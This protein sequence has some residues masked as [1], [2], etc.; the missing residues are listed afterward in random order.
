MPKPP[1]PDSDTAQPAE[2]TLETGFDEVLPEGVAAGAARRSDPEWVEAT[3]TVTRPIP[4]EALDDPG[5]PPPERPARRPPR[6]LQVAAIAGVAVLVLGAAL[7][8]RSHHRKQVLAKG[9]AHAVRVSWADTHAGYREASQVLEPLVPIDVLEAGAMRAYALA[10]LA[11]DYRD[12]RAG[13]EAE[14]LLLEPERATEVPSAAN[15]ARAA[16]ALGRREAGTAATYAARPGG[17]ALAGVIQG[18]VALMAGNP[19]GA[20]EPLDAALLVDP[21]L[22][23]AL[24]LKGDALRRTRSPAAARQAYLAA[25]ESSPLHP[26]AAYGLAKLA[27]SAQARPDDA[28]PA[29]ER[30]L[31]DRAGTPSNER[32][33]AALHLAALK[34]RAG[35]RA[36][37][38][39]AIEAAGA[40]GPDRAWLEKAVAEEELSRTG[41][42]VVDGAPAALRSA[43]DDDPYEPAPPSPPPEAKK[44]MAKKAPAKAVKPAKKGKPAA[45]APAKKSS[46]TGTS[47]SSGK[48]SPAKPATP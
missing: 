37:A 24:A 43:S 13:Q 38:Q 19:A 5:E 12:E 32:G 41:Y 8:Y 45:K 35:D 30:I 31:G 26:R 7:L 27:L 15:V 10:M 17:G 34:G 4:A 2:P 46:K 21:R 3:D 9:L 29:L 40:S 1:P 14:A 22:P 28:I 36:G 48:K 18:R 6:N 42:H 39:K 23:A 16:L 47:K 25:L 44:V 20:L 11:T 33:R